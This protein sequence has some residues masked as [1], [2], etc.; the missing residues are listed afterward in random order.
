MPRKKSSEAESKEDSKKNATDAK[1]RKSSKKELILESTT[2][3]DF[4][5]QNYGD[6]PQNSGDSLISA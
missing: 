3:W 6:I 5:T 4:P 1:K 2:L